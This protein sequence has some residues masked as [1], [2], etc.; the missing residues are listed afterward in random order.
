MRNRHQVGDCKMDARFHKVTW[1][2]AMEGF[3]LRQPR[4]APIERHLPLHWTWDWIP[5]AELPSALVV[6]HHAGA[7]GTE[8]WRSRETLTY[9][10]TYA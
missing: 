3:L 4:L 9:I 2:R 1:Q 10:I 6:R 8:S 7:T 5:G